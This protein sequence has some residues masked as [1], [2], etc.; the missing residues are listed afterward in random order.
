MPHY[1]V[2]LRFE[3][4]AEDDEV[5]KKMKSDMLGEAFGKAMETSGLTCCTMHKLTSQDHRVV[6]EFHHPMERAM[7]PY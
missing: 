4:T 7:F 6:E 2:E 3:V 5:A 1:L